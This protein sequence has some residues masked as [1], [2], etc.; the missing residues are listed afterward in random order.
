MFHFRKSLGFWILNLHVCL[1]YSFVVPKATCQFSWASP[2]ETLPYCLTSF[3][4][5]SRRHVWG[6]VNMLLR[7][8]LGQE[9]ISS[10]P[11]FKEF[12]LWE[13]I[14][15]VVSPEVKKGVTAQIAWTME[16]HSTSF[17]IL[18]ELSG[19]IGL[20][21]RKSIK[22][23]IKGPRKISVPCLLS[24]ILPLPDTQTFPA[25]PSVQGFEPVKM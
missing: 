12:I 10:V 20:Q 4:H 17:I 1:Y 21:F 23:D 8:L 7:I 14:W 11:A 2:L 22:H 25:I 5:S 15:P 18:S 16:V 13:F 24:S 9:R 3:T 19:W 6:T